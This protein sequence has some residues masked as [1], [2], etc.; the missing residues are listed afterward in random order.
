MNW[1]II[2]GFWPANSDGDDIVIYKSEKRD[3]M[4]KKLFFLRQQVNRKRSKRPNFCLADFVAPVGVQKD[5]IGG[6]AV[7]AGK[8]IECGKKSTF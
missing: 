2:L 4:L 6:F 7:T 1:R 5:Y 8:G 3:K